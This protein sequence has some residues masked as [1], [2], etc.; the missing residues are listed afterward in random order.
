MKWLRQDFRTVSQSSSISTYPFLL[1]T[2]GFTVTVGMHLVW[3]YSLN[4]Q[5]DKISWIRLTWNQ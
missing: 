3:I 5:E 2:N 1:V 4:T